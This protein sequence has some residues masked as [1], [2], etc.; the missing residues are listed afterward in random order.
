MVFKIL[1]LFGRDKEK[2]TVDL[3]RSLLSE[4]VVA[5]ESFVACVKALLDEDFKVVAEK[6]SDVTKHE[7]DADQIISKIILHLYSGAF[8]PG[9]RTQLHELAIYTDDVIDNMQ[10]AVNAFG[11]MKGKKF[12]EHVKGAYWKLADESRRSVNQL[13]AVLEDLFENKETIM[14]DV[15]AAKLMEHNCD[16]LKKEIFD[17]VMFDKKI[18]AIS[19]RLLTDLATFISSIADS[20]E[21]CCDKVTVLKLLRQA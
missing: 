16:V 13:Q 14:E 19:S 15:K 9:M 5:N 10:N 20:V 1:P 2:E 18:D 3:F 11:Y 6:A 21:D 12:P 8:L 7:K 17:K 4:I